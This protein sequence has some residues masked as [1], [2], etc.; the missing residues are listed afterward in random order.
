L[1]EKKSLCTKMPKNSEEG[2]GGKTKGVERNLAR[3]KIRT[4]TERVVVAPLSLSLSLLLVRPVRR[5]VY[6][7]RRV[8]ARSRFVIPCAYSTPEPFIDAFRC[9]ERRL[10]PRAH[11]LPVCTWRRLGKQANHTLSHSVH[12]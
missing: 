10:S 4:R 5:C 1:G 7:R 6:Y 2:D 8:V 3:K 9:A 12:T 11:I